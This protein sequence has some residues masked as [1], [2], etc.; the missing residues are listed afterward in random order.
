MRLKNI[1]L[2]TFIGAVFGLAFGA[3]AAFFQNGPTVTAGMLESWW[4]FAIAGLLKGA[5]D[6]QKIS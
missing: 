1:L 4:W 3:I 5:T 6:P 2:W